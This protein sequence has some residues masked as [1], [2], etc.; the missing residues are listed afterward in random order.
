MS[1]ID[2]HPEELFDRLS[3]GTLTELEAE[4]LRAHLAICDVCRFELSTR[5]DFRAELAALPSDLSAPALLPAFDRKASSPSD[6]ARS[7]ELQS[8]APA[9]TRRTR[10][11]R[12]L[13]WFFAAAGLFMA[14]GALAS[15]VSGTRPWQLLGSFVPS[16]VPGVPSASVAARPGRRVMSSQAALQAA[17]PLSPAPSNSVAG[18]PAVDV[19]DI[20]PPLRTKRPAGSQESSAVKRARS[21]EAPHEEGSSA[22][23]LFASA[24]RARSSGQTARA[25]SL[26]RQLQTKYPR[27]G[28][29][30]LSELT[31]ATLLLHVGDARSALSGFDRYLARGARPLQ[32]EALVGRAL[33]QR[34]LGQ[35]EPE[36]AT[37]A[38]VAARFPGTSYARR[39]EERLGALGRR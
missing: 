21:V 12:G 35:R 15:V 7:P 31:L 38:S 8:S 28:E 11:R 30:E 22:S 17:A 29:A 33:A 1:L 36:I 37:W 16:V 4:R 10:V 3:A 9:R 18:A 34:A 20:A 2:I 19:G 27:S 5:S 39:A 6:L 13:V 14:T 26:Y 23:E 24:N 32:A 25:V